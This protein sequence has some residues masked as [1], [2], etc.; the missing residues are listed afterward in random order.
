MVGCG[1]NKNEQKGGEGGVKFL[2]NLQK[3]IG[4][5]S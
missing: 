2:Q 5:N 1:T 4:G 3:R